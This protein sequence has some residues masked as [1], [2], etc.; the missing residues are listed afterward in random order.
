MSTFKNFINQLQS[1]INLNG[2][3]DTESAERSIKGNIHFRGPNAWILA[4]AT[5]IA[6]IGLNVNSIPVIIG[7]MLISP[8]MGPI[9][10]IGLGLGINDMPLM[11]SS[12]KN[13]LITLF[14][15]FL[16]LLIG[17][18][19]YLLFGQLRFTGAGVHDDGIGFLTDCCQLC[20]QCSVF[21]FKVGHQRYQR[22]CFLVGSGGFDRCLNLQFPR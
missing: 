6:S 19:V 21:G 11:K 1:T 8:L 15:I 2:Y 18:I 14:T 10:G 7:A 4:I 20:F 5:I 3:I 13:L 22:F 17:F 12:V 16:F 9:F